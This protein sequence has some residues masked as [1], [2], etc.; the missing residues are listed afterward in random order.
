[1]SFAVSWMLARA[2][3][4][5][6]VTHPCTTDSRETWGSQ[7]RKHVSTCS[8]TIS[9]RARPFDCSY[10]PMTSSIFSIMAPAVSSNGSTVLTS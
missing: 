10:S 4:S 2:T 5:V 3:S 9:A 1:M 7:L 6:S 8:A